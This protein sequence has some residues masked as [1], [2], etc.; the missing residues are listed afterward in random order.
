MKLS[1]RVQ[2]MQNSPIRKFNPMAAE[3]KAQGTK[4]YHLNIGQPDIETP[5]VFMEAIRNFDQKVLAYAESSGLAELQDAII[6]Y[7]KRFD[8]SLERKHVLVTSGGSEALTLV[9]LSLI[10]PGDEVIVAEPYYTNYHTFITAAEGV[11][12]PVTTYAEE[13][14]KYAIRERLEKVV[15]DKTKMISLVNPGNPTGCILSR[16][17]MRVICDFAKE[18][19][20]WIL[21]DEVYREFAYD[22]REMTSFGQYPDVEDR[23][24]I[25][26]SVSKRFSACGARIGCLVCKNDDFM[27]NVM[28]I[29]M[30]RLCCP[31]L[32]MVGATAMYKM[33][34][35]FFDGVRKEYEHRRDVS[36]EALKKIPGVVCEK[37]GGAF[38]ITCKLPV[39]NA[40]DLLVFLLKEFRDN[41]ET[42]MYAP[43]E[44]FY[45][46]P[47][48]GKN[49]LRIAYILNADDMARGIELLGKGIEAYK[50]AGHK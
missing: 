34:P 5:P 12:K 36:Y 30:G 27:A 22:G 31:T 16:D 39:E 8:M 45:A 33:D 2:A 10:N 20:L 40:E 24:I 15:T 44:G 9:F 17:D 35:S 4:I 42:V 29:A 28:K 6:D 38:Y 7:F 49:E 14:Y 32:E 48:I 19:D 25:I 1:D 41:G 43:A 3:A 13:G 47:G 21:A 23:V 46:T 18:H 11:I 26:D 50:A 37:P